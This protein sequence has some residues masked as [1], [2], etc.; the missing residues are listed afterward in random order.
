MSIEP[1]RLLSKIS[2]IHEQVASINDLLAEKSKEEILSDQWLV[3]GIKY[4]LQTSVEA[5]IDIAYHISAKVYNHAPS[6]A[7]DALKVL[8]NNGLIS[9]KDLPVYGAMVG[10]RNRVVHGYGEV[11]PERVYEIALTELGDLENGGTL[12]KGTVNQIAKDLGFED[13]A[14]MQDFLQNSKRKR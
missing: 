13:A 4:S 6:E 12:A 5:M 3:K 8:A 2:F 9:Q 14:D 10:F 1:E 7:R 11:T